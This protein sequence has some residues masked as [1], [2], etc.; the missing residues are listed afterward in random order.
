IDKV[1]VR[2][3]RGI[4]ESE[5]KKALA[6]QEREYW[7]LPGKLQRQRSDE[8]IERILAVYNDNGYVQARVESHEIQVDRQKATVNLI[9]TVVEGPQYGVENLTITGVTLFPESEVLCVVQLKRDDIYSRT[10]LSEPV[11]ELHYA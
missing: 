10:T 11:R 3:A 7:I 1:S 8:D 2:G 9:F 4:E 5:L 6:T